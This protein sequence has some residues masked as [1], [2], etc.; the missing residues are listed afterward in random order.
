E[1]ILKQQP[2]KTLSYVDTWHSARDR[3]SAWDFQRVVSAH[4][5]CPIPLKPKQFREI[6]SFL[7]RPKPLAYCALDPG[8]G[9]DLV[10]DLHKLIGR[11]A[12]I[13]P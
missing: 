3:I 10:C 9:G 7:T 1:L 5:D 13:A 12:K 6:F 4:F 2:E 11:F 8:C